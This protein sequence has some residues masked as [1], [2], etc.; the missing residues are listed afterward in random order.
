MGSK[1]LNGKKTMALGMVQGIGGGSHLT[2]ATNLRV[3]AMGTNQ[4]K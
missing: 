1:E 4:K 2:M 3:Q